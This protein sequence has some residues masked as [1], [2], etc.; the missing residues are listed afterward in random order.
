MHSRTSK[1]TILLRWV[2][3]ISSFFENKKKFLP[4]TMAR[5]SCILRAKRNCSSKD[6]CSYQRECWKLCRVY[7]LWCP[8]LRIVWKEMCFN[9]GK[10][11][12]VFGGRRKGPLWTTIIYSIFRRGLDWC[13]E[14]FF[15]W[16]IVGGDKNIFVEGFFL[17]Q[18]NFY[19][20][21]SI[22]IGVS[23]DIFKFDF[24]NPADIVKSIWF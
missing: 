21:D 6:A 8:M 16:E 20:W 15:A 24:I 17:K 9:S 13:T 11:H 23:H 3:Y 5:K 14:D 22:H 2:Y 10:W 4:P 7:T 1:H 12:F 18:N 19:T